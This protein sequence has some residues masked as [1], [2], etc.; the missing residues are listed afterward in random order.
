VRGAA[1]WLDGQDD[2]PVLTTVRLPVLTTVRFFFVMSALS[3]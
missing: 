1:S 3:F 2:L